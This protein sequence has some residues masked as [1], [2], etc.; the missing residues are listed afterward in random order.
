MVDHGHGHLWFPIRRDSPGPDALDRT[1]IQAPLDWDTPRVVQ[2]A[3]DT[4]LFQ[5]DIESD[6]IER[7]ISTIVATPRHAYLL[8]TRCAKR[9]LVLGNEGLR[10]PGN[11]WLGV[12]VEADSDLWR[13]E[14]LLRCNS[15]HPWVAAEPLLGPVSSIPVEMLSWV[16]CGRDHTTDLDWVRDLRDRCLAASVPF[17]FHRRADDGS[18]ALEELDGRTWTGVPEGWPPVFSG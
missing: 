11:L 4:D 6:V 7:I 18:V 13:V 9:L 17:R 3:P 1:E 2:V 8:S 14:D 10:F 5:A 15:A 12:T 16:V